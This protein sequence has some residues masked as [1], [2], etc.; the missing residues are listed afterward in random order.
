MHMTTSDSDITPLH[1]LVS[2]GGSELAVRG[3]THW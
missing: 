1:E 2:K 3:D